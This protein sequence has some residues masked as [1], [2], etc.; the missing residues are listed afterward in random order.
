MSVTFTGT[1]VQWI[2]P[3]NTNGGI[4]DVYL[5]GNQVATVDT[6]SPAGKLF[7]QVLYSTTG[8]AQGSHT[9]TITVSGQ[10]N[11]ASSSDTVVIDAINV[12]T[13]AQQADYYPVV[14]QQGSLTVAGRE[15]DLLVANYSFGGQQL[16]YSTSQ[17][18]TQAT[19]GGQA[20][21]L[22]YG[23]AGTDGETVLRYTS[24]PTV[25][26]LSGS[27]QS[28]WD[29]GRG[30]LR[31]DYVHHGL[32]E[33]QITGGGTPPLRLLIATPTW[34]RNSGRSPRLT[35]GRCWSAA[36]TWSA[37][38]P[39]TAPLLA[40]TGDTSQPARSP[41][42]H[43]PASGTSP[44]TGSRSA[45]PPARTARCRAACP[46]RSRSPCPASPAGGS[47]TRHPRCSPASTTVPGRW[48]TTR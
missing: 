48:P 30:D 12:P 1:A 38:R 29:A 22:L 34:P 25:T 46:A 19:I 5:D 14:P 32:A 42:G 28:A 33:V 8:L 21:A 37:P 20:I 11:P 23:D 47:A 9:L 13:A 43:R 7:Q 41:S 17:L 24:Q 6:Y 39:A 4:A 36:V 10:K 16:I 2:G 45:S 35:R 3:E 15:A 31:L 26:V 27:V 44:G 18:M 40:L